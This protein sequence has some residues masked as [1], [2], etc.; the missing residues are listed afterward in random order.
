MS[1]LPK[2]ISE[3]KLADYG[4]RKIDEKT[5]KHV[6]FSSLRRLCKDCGDWC[7]Q[8]TNGLCD[9]CSANRDCQERIAVPNFLLDY[10]IRTSRRNRAGKR[11]R[12]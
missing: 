6:R 4:Y 10:D 5:A 9:R 3:E 11:W 12:R 7:I 8:I 1:N 2:R